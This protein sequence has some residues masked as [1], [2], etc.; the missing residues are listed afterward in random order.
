MASAV[1]RSKNG[2]SA[3]LLF[4]GIMA[5]ISRHLT[6]LDVVFIAQPALT[7]CGKSLEIF[8]K[9]LIISKITAFYNPCIS[10]CFSNTYNAEKYK[11]YILK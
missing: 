10:Y 3:F 4:R 1:C 5:K 11:A 2:A 6:V 8:H 7:S 9:Q